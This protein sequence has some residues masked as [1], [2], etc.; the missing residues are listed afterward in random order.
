MKI[1]H[2]LLL[3]SFLLPACPNEYHRLKGW[4]H[5][6]D[7]AQKVFVYC[8]WYMDAFFQKYLQPLKQGSLH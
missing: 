5:T 8:S 4:P 6:M 3:F 2:V 1:F 7:V